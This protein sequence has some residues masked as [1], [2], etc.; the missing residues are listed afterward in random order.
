MTKFAPTMGIEEELQ[1]VHAQSHSLTPDAHELLE[2]A[3][4]ELKDEEVVPELRQSQIEI[5]SG[6][7]QSLDEVTRELFRL[8]KEVYEASTA[9]G[10]R[11]VSAGTHP[12]SSWKE[13]PVTK[14]ERY[15]EIEKQYQHL[16]REQLIF[17]LHIH[18]GI[19]D[20]EEAVQVLN[21]LRPWLSVLL[22]L[23]ANSPF[24][25]G[26]D[27][28]YNSFRTEL[29]SRWPLSG[30]PGCFESYDEYQQTARQL[31]QCDLVDD[32]SKIYWDMRI[33]TKLP[34]IEIRMCDACTR[35]ED[36]TMLVGLVRGLVQRAIS[37]LREQT[38]SPVV[39]SEIL[40]AAH[41]HAARYGLDGA[42]PDTSAGKSVS[43]HEMVTKLLE[44]VRAG[45]EA[46]GDW[47]EVSRLVD[48]TLT[49]GNGA[50]RQRDIF[51][52]SGNLQSVV[53]YLVEN[54]CRGLSD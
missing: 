29:W 35:I 13:Q 30:V 43:A 17:G 49:I 14:G 48:E 27:T 53:E 11:I 10:D 4:E 7:C 37:D 22:A 2:L 45:L 54:T 20:R 26:D 36:V 5:V 15:R 1:I 51:A 38:P 44:H 3:R 23:S 21:R 16:A 41:W 19:E 34:T 9:K 33:P 42:L 18:I 46:T 50:K 6:V 28:G 24:W 52:Q 31:Q 39:R 47:P 25:N 32:G 40:R 12:F 8:R